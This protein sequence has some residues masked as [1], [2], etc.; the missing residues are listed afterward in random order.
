MLRLVL[1]SALGALLLSS[2]PLSAQTTPDMV[3]GRMRGTWDLPV[4][5]EPGRARGVLFYLGEVVVGLDARLT[6]MP[7]P[8]DMRG[9][10][11]DGILRRKTDTGFAPEPIAEVHGTFI[12]GPDRMG[13]FEAVI[14]PPE[15]MGVRPEPIGK[16]AGAFADPM[17]G[18]RDP[19]GRFAGRWALM[20]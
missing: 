16:M 5:D 20:M 19:V 10:R 12:V 13:R 8:G 15:T 18:D 11:I 6:P 9:G 2:A 1:A 4:K 17:I 7:M 14:V 3:G